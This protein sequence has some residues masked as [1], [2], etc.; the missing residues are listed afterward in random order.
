MS[1]F[2]YNHLEG[3]EE[4]ADNSKYGTAN[5]IVVPLLNVVGLRQLP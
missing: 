5:N 2:R 3:Q 4:V 1:T